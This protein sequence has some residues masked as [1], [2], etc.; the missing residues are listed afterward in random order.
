MDNELKNQHFF[1]HLEDAY[2]QHNALLQPS[3]TMNL[4]PQAVFAGAGSVQP[5]HPIQFPGRGFNLKLRLICKA[6][7][8]L[9][10]SK[11]VDVRMIS[12]SILLERNIPP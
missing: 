11:K 8:V 3:Q 6:R 1:R 2:R 12:N 4:T 9:S 10:H 7:K 5:Q